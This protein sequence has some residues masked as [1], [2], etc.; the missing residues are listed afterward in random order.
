VRFI[1]VL[2]FDRSGPHPHEQPETVER[3]RPLVQSMHA[4]GTLVDTG[5]RDSEMIEFRVTRKDGRN[6]VTDGPFAESK[7]V[8][9]GYAVLEVKDRAHA[10]AVTNRFLET[11]GANA[12]CDLYEVFPP[13]ELSP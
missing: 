10:A 3:M 4:D 5:G 8:V 12:T 13:P 11:L 1:S 9:G 6:A 7:E 2:T